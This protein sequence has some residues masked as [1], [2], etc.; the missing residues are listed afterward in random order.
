VE[1][2]ATIVGNRVFAAEIHSQNSPKTRDDWRR[3]DFDNTPHLP[4]QL[5]LDMEQKCVDLVRH[6]NLNFGAIDLILTPQGEYVFLE[7]NP[8][9]Q[10]GWI[11]ELTGLPICAAIV[12]LLVGGKN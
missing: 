9:G 10:W 8:N 11:E 6:L 7:I 12:D 5:P 4:H 1:I 3:Y 2:R